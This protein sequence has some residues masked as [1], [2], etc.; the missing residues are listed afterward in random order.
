MELPEK[1]SQIIHVKE[2][3]LEFG[4]GQICDHPKD[5]LYL[6]GPHSA[7]DRNVAISVGVIGTSK[8]IGFL[9]TTLEKM[10]GFIEIPKPGLRDKE[11]RLHLSHFPGLTEAFGIFV[12]QDAIV[13]RTI[14][15]KSIEDA[16]RNLNHHE[17]VRKA[18]DLYVSEIE[19]HNTNEEQEIDV[20]LLVLPEIIFERCKTLSKRTGVPLI[21]G[22]FGKKQRKPADVPLFQDVIDLSGEEIFQDI[23]DFHRQLKARLLGVGK[24]SQLVRETT[25]APDEFLNKA[26]YPVRGLQ[27]PATVAW[28]LATGLYYK[29]RPH[30]PWKLI[31]AREGVCYI[32]LVFKLIPNHPQHHACC[33]AQMFLNEG[34]GLVFRGA[35]GPWET[36][37]NEFHLPPNKARELLRFWTPLLQ[38]MGRLPKSF[39]FMGAQSL[40]MM[41]GM[42]F[43]KPAQKKLILFMCASKKHQ[44]K[45]SYSGTGIIL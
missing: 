31:S 23:P 19:H 6:Y 2:P 44:A 26:G 34:D 42:R 15:Q 25:L 39:L 43:A 36:R 5:G 12:E 8:G 11:H 16:T 35:N 29:T 17:A 21:K 20:W 9:K 4:H 13:E 3:E 1:F 22:D 33:A 7:P 24:T 27:D 30:P 10:S 14:S 40:V 32:G 28:N 41:S 38:S 37:R 18:V 45:R